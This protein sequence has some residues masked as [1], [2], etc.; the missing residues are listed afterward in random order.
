MALALIVSPLIGG[1]MSQNGDWRWIFYYNV[2]AGG[3]SLILLGFILPARFPH[4]WEPNLEK[5]RHASVFH[6]ASSFARKADP[7]GA[8]L[9]LGAIIFLVAALEEG[10]VRF[11]WDSGVVIA[12]LVLSGSLAILFVGWMAV[13]SRAFGVETMFPSRFASNHTLLSSLVGCIITGAPM[14]IA[15]IELPQRY[16][17]VNQSSPL[18]AGVKLLAYAVAMPVGIVL[19]SIMSGRLRL[20]FIYILFIGAMMQTVGFALLSTVPTTTDLWN[21]I[22]GYSVLMGLG[23][24][25]CAGTYYV[26]TPIS[27]GKGDQHLALGSGL[28]CR[29]LGGAIGNAG[30]SGMGA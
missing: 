25:I 9:V 15:A 22:F 13:A 1:A 6:A 2:P 19:G 16:Q 28:Q 30:S 4:H 17:L 10:G 11:A 29:M 3:A 12:F 5:T 27:S 14:T 8:F 26:I 20:A 24:G 23:V 7:V 18:G 21:G